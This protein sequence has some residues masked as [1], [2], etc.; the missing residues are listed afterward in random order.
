MTSSRPLK[1]Q[2]SVCGTEIHQVVL[3][4]N[5][6]RSALTHQALVTVLEDRD[7]KAGLR[8]VLSIVFTT[9]AALALESAEMYCAI[10]SRSSIARGDHVLL[11]EPFTKPLFDF[12]LSN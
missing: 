11:D 4:R 8:V 5:S 3:E 1:K 9:V 12:F 10:A 2:I 7:S 6:R